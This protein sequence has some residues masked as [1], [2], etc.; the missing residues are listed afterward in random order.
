VKKLT[1]RQ[2]KIAAVGVGGLLFLV[3][4]LARQRNAENAKATTPDGTTVPTATG[5]GGTPGDF[6]GDQAGVLGGMSNDITGALASVNTGLETV[7]SNEG[8]LYDAIGGLSAGQATQQASIDS[9]AGNLSALSDRI[10]ATSPATDTATPAAA[11]TATKAAATVQPKTVVK[12]GKVYHYYD[13]DP[14][15]AGYERKVYVR[16][17]GTP[18]RSPSTPHPHT[19]PAPASHH[20]TAKKAPARKA[21][22]K[23][24]PARRPTPRRKP[25][26]TRKTRR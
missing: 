17:A 24:A 25:T 20:T 8:V 12:D 9:L 11:A 2:K 16:P 1:D 26:P 18:R 15:K 13:T 10:P 4:M 21:P 3:F 6:S 7:G 5:G 22:A 23:R 14:K 19:K